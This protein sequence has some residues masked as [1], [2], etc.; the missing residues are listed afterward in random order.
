MTEL[1]GPGVAQLRELARRLSALER[2]LHLNEGP[3]FIES[4]WGA[5]AKTGGGGVPARAGTT[6]GSATVT[7]YKSDLTTTVETVTAKNLA[8]TAVAADTWILLLRE[9]P[10]REWMVVWEECPA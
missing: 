6:L 10:T 5:I 1:T 9:A 8:T 7:I 2:Q 3:R 4:A